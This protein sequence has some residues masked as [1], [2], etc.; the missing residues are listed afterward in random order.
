MKDDWHERLANGTLPCLCHLTPNT[1]VGR[2]LAGGGGRLRDSL[3]VVGGHG[4][5]GVGVLPYKVAHSACDE[6]EAVGIGAL[7]DEIEIGSR[8][9]LQDL[10]QWDFLQDHGSIGDQKQKRCTVLVY[11]RE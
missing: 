8:A 5:E 1:T 6:L 3:R 4:G 11:D 7:R 9:H 2:H 10:R